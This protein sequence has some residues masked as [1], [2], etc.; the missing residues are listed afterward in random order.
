MSANKDGDGGWKSFLWNSEKKEF[1]GRTGGSWFKILLFYLIFYG[2]LAGIF[3]GTIQALLLTLSNFKPTY[4][5][6]VAPPG[7]SHTPRSEKFEISYNINDVET[8]LKYT[9]SIKDFLEMYDEER[10]TDQNKYEDCGELPASYVDRGELESDVGVRK[11]CR[12]KRTWLGPCS[13]LDGHDENFGFKDGKPCLIAKLNRIINFRPRPPTN[14]ASVPDA[15][16]SRVQTN[17]I[18]IHCQNKREE[19]AS[20][21]G[22][23]K[24]YGMGMGFP[25]Q[26]YPYYGKLLHPNYLQPLVAI[27]FTNLTFNEELRLE[28][29]VYGAN[30][31]YSEKDRYQGRFDVKFTI[32]NS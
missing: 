24:Y 19:D 30:I 16:Q 18:P 26:Y 8:Y 4:Q 6:R 15:G 32:A 17:V 11:A 14:N 29:K 21:I 7:L 10:Q 3:I 31:D 13:G 9:K 2:C 22:E 25:L 1:L 27:Q 20:K 12:F 23:I 28:C 5:D